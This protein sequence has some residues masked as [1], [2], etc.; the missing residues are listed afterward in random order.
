M[1]ASGFDIGTRFVKVCIVEGRNVLGYSIEETGKDMR[2][3]IKAAYK[4]ALERSG[5]K[6]R[7]VE[8]RMATGY[9]SELVRK[10]DAVVPE[11]PCLARAVH[12]LNPEIRLAVD[13]GGLF[14]NVTG[15]GA[16]G[17]V[18]G[19]LTNDKCAAGSGKFLEMVSETLSVPFD[20]ISDMA[21]RSNSPYA[22]NSQCAVFAESEIISQVNGG[23]SGEDILAGVLKSIVLRAATLVERSDAS[24]MVALCGGISKIPAFRVLFERTIKSDA[25]I[26]PLDPQIIAAYGAA[27]LAEGRAAVRNKGSVGAACPGHARVMESR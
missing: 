13:V 20:S 1:I 5:V 17:F 11:A 3:I 12:A 14:I 4:R 2:R 6:K 10:A 27:L 9:G 26:P 15:V 19:T 8:R 7:A 21:L 23:R 16:R 22:I 25:Y 18:D 24:G